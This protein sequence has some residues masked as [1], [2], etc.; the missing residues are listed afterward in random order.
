MCLNLIWKCDGK[1]A[2]SVYKGSYM[3]AHVLSWLLNLLNEMGKKTLSS[4][5]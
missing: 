5:L 4:I 1:Y 2:Q 3:S